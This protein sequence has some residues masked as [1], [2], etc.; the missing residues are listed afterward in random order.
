MEYRINSVGSLSSKCVYIY[1]TSSL[2]QNKG[3]YHR[4]TSEDTGQSTERGD[5]LGRR[6][7]DDDN[8]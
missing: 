6:E 2:A 3:Q 5:L 8:E 7:G 1:E 4:P